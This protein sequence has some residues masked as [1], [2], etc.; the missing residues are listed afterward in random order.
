MRHAISFSK[1]VKLLNSVHK[2]FSLVRIAGQSLLQHKLRSGL[3]ILGIVCGVMAMLTMISVGEGAKYELLRQIERLGTKNIYVQAREMTQTQKDAAARK[4]SAGLRRTDVERIL[5]GS[6]QIKA[7]ATLKEIKA[8]V[9]GIAPDIT[10]QVVATS[11]NYAV[12]MGIPL[13]S[14][15]FINGLDMDEE[16]LVCV[17]GDTL[18]ESLGR[19][20]QMGNHIRIESHLFKVVG[21]LKRFQ[22]NDEKAKKTAISI[23]DYNEMLFIPAGLENIF[24]GRR[25]SLEGSIPGNITEMIIQVKKTD[26]VFQ[27]GE[28]IKR[29]MQRVHNGVSDYLIIIP[30]ELLRQSRQTQKTF[31]MVLGA[32]AG[33]SLLVG[34]IGIMN[35]M[36][37]SVSERTREIGLRRAVGATRVDILQHFLMESVILTFSGGII[38]VLGGLAAAVM[39]AEIAEWQTR[40]TLWSVLTPVMMSILVGIFSGLYPALQASRMDPIKALRHE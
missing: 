25:E 7:V 8:A 16:K 15:R 31:N 6:E 36:L 40:I 20:G 13:S 19:E 10:P 23:R 3:S 24:T 12:I 35:V 9:L 37:A 2:F 11:A 39:I 33:V 18:A 34:G 30:Q 27:T 28:I 4:L 26:Y 21:R 14:G 22:K 29:I 32:I 5:Q 38:G 1:M 17:L